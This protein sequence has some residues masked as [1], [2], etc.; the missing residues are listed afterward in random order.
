MPSSI[1]ALF[2]VCLLGPCPAEEVEDTGDSDELR[3]S[4]AVFYPSPPAGDIVRDWV[5]AHLVYPDTPPWTDDA[6]V[7]QWM[8]A[9]S[10][11][12]QLN[13]QTDLFGSSAG[14]ATRQLSEASGHPMS[15][16]AAFTA[17]AWDLGLTPSVP[18]ITTRRTRI[19]YPE[20]EHA[21]AAMIKAG[22][23]V[24][25]YRHTRFLLGTTH[26]V[27]AA[28]LAL[29]VQML[30]DR[31]KRLAKPSEV[32][33]DPAI[34]Q[35]YLDVISLED[36]TDSDLRL[37]MRQLEAGLSAWP[38][39]ELS[40]HEKRQLPAIFR[41]ARLAAAY[42]EQ[43]GHDGAPAP[44]DPNGIRVSGVAAEYVGE[45]GKM[46]C[47]DTANDRAV[48]QWYRKAYAEE[49]STKLAG[50]TL[51]ATMRRIGRAIDDVRPFWVGALGHAVRFRP[52]TYELAVQAM[53]THARDASLY[54]E[55][56]ITDMFVDA[57]E[58]LCKGEAK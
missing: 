57:T 22:V 50:A 29:S 44:C 39:G 48:V 26:P 55:S 36:L 15:R 34:V 2:F 14:A 5:T 27:Q 20:N 35:R 31:L 25:I 56:V 19:A 42:R 10:I 38:G 16:A 43:N 24:D 11:Y 13:R 3:Y 4:D 41:L 8:G 54:P 18:W 53:A 37:L 47:F 9:Y 33:L 49:V 23:D 12:G 28:N 21:R 6:F 1:A 51:T 46:P 52:L 40:T 17:M 32:G 58:R 45:A 30:R 7:R